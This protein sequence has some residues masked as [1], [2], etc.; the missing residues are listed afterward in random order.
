[1]VSFDSLRY[2]ART[3]TVYYGMSSKEMSKK[4]FS[5]FIVFMRS[6]YGYLPSDECNEFACYSLMKR[7]FFR[8]LISKHHLFAFALV[9][10]IFVYV[11]PMFRYIIDIAPVCGALDE[12]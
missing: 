2:D 9:S 10:E 8:W 1:M 6:K 7:Y 11:E 12:L 4:D 5:D 3:N